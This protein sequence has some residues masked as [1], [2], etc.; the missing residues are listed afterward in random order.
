V[1]SSDSI[2]GKTGTGCR[3]CNPNAIF[4]TRNGPSVHDNLASYTFFGKNN[5]SDLRSI[6]LICGTWF[7]DKAI[8]AVRGHGALNV[9]SPCGIISTRQASLNWSWLLQET[10]KHGP[11]FFTSEIDQELIFRGKR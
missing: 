10:F 7:W 6:A 9:E 8:L 11:L 1:R 3:V 4:S 2:K 5:L